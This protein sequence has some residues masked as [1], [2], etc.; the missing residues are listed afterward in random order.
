[1]R[2]RT[3][4]SLAGALAAGAASPRRIGANDPAVDALVAG[5]PQ[6]WH[7]IPTILACQAGKQR[8]LDSA[9]VGV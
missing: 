4:L 9:G 1:M 8:R 2:R 7:A 3:F 6:H 5:T